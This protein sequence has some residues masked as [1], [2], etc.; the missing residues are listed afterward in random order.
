MNLM[1][2]EEHLAILRQGT[3]VWNQWRKD[4]PDIRPDLSGARLCRAELSRAHLFGT[5]LSEVHLGRADLSVADLSRADLGGADL[6]EANLHGAK[7][8]GANLHRANLRKA[9]LFRAD[10]FGVQ[11]SGVDLTGADLSEATVGGTTF[12]DTD[13]S[14]VSGLDTTYHVGP[15]TIGI[16][17]IYRSGGNI[18]EAFVR[19]ACVPDTFITYIHSLVGQPIEF[20]SCFI[21]YSSKDHE[22]AERL[23]NDLQ[24]KGVRCWFAPEDLKIGDRFRSRIDEAIRIHDKLLLVL[25]KNSIESAWVEGEVETA[26]EKERQ[27]NRVVLFPIRLDDAVMETSQAWAADIRRIRQ[28]GDFSGWKDPNR[29]QAAFR[30]LLR[31]L[32][33]EAGGQEADRQ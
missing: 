15:S 14:E 27:Q 8:R 17:T 3:E 23:H 18:P 12:G 25:S 31:D 6:S 2:N 1:A 11:L 29:Y 4:N 7:L 28:I 20:Y 13:L 33:A 19:G 26:F 21:S 9:G 5:D 16:D 32:K 24:G 30:R 22:F 10:L